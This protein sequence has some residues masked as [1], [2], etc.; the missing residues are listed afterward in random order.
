MKSI[1]VIG[2]GV[3]GKKLTQSIQKASIQNQV[4]LISSRVFL[5]NTPERTF[6]VIW[7]AGRPGSQAKILEIAQSISNLVILEKPLGATLNDFLRVEELIRG[8]NSNIDLSMP[9]CY[10]NIWL[11]L[12]ERIK[13]WDL[14]GASLTFQRSGPVAHTYI[15]PVEDWI[16]HDIY[17][18]SDIL[19]SYE[20]HALVR[21]MKKAFREVVISLELKREITLNFEFKVSSS[22]ESKFELITSSNSAYVDF[23]NNRLLINGEAS[24]ISISSGL[25]EINRN[26]LAAISTEE[27]RTIQFVRTQTWMKLLID[28][29]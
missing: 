16:P 5:S 7:I 3:W 22:K 10:S 25:D 6:D 9:W 11:N 8:A 28:S 2:Q 17:L 13:Y 27:S 23:L 4:E 12:K 29:A 14:K 18:A 15:S 1:A 26:L 19:P 20:E 21:S 24:E